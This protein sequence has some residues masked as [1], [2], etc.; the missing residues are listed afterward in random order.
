MINFISYAMVSRDSI[1]RIV[2][3][4]EIRGSIRVRGKRFFFSPKR[5]HR[6][7]GQPFLL[8]GGY[9]K[10]FLGVVKLSGREADILSPCSAEGHV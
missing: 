8:F 2:N 7:W 4:M 10:L 5:P 1:V 6:L 9:R 3:G